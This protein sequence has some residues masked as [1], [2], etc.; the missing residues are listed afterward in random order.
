MWWSQSPSLRQTPICIL[1][2]PHPLLFFFFFWLFQPY[3]FI[4]P[5]FNMFYTV[6]PQLQLSKVNQ[7]TSS[8]TAKSPKPLLN[9]V[10][11]F[12]AINHNYLNSDE[13]N[14]NICFSYVWLYQK[15]DHF[16]YLEWLSSVEFLK[17]KNKFMFKIINNDD[18]LEK[19]SQK[20]YRPPAN[21]PFKRNHLHSVFPP[22]IQSPR[23]GS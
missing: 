9:W 5:H 15:P 17:K 18:N 7:P 1:N 22:L 4:P 10:Y 11:L 20:K 6:P 21:L 3:L 16:C 2:M 8:N 12:P 13:T 14:Q 23:R 19:I